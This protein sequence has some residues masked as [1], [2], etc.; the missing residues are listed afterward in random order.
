[1]GARE[2]AKRIEENKRSL[3]CAPIRTKAA[4]EEYR[5]G[6]DRAFGKSKKDVAEK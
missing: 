4:T 6:W 2:D 3:D 1:M 5:R